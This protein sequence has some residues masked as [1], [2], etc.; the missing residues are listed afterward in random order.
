M[1]LLRAIVSIVGLCV[2][3][4]GGIFTAC[5]SEI[6]PVLR[7]DWRAAYQRPP[8]ISH[9]DENPWSLKKAQLG[10]VL[11]FDPI[12]SSSHTMSCGTCHQPKLA[13]SDDLPKSVGDRKISMALRSPTLLNV[14]WLSRLG[15]DGK[16]PDIESVSFRAIAGDAN[17]AL[18][19]KEAL[20]RLSANPAY[21]RRFQ[22]TF[23]PGGITQEKVEQALATYQRGIVSTPSPFDR[24]VAGDEAAV[25][26]SAKRGFA[27]FDGKGGCANCHQGWAFTDG[28]FHDIGTAHGSDVGRGAM[29]PSSVALRYAFKVPTLRDVDVRAPYMHDGSL[30]TLEAVVGLYDRG[31]INRPSRSP[32]IRALGLTDAEKADL[33]DFL[34]TLTGDAEEL[35]PALSPR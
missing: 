9:P 20:E 33:I 6:A 14:A 5:G 30:A 21:V 10:A 23:G 32:N 26:A 4:A 25:S 12:L 35:A 18:S 1:P 19:V 2:A 34:R 29:F 13:W 8:M 24:W 11:F 17:M 16:F 15:W 3:L 27:V 28:S 7:T 22:A 31:G